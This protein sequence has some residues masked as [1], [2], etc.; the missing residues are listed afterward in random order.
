MNANKYDLFA[1]G[2]IDYSDELGIANLKAA[3]DYLVK[4]GRG[5]SVRRDKSG[6]TY[7]RIDRV[8]TGLETAS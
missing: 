8:N 3:L 5:E 7:V 1:L 6:K 4:E 2:I